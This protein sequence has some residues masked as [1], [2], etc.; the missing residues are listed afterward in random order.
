MDKRSANK[1]SSLQ[2]ISEWEIPWK[3]ESGG[4]RSKM[5]LEE[6]MTSLQFVLEDY[7]R[8]SIFCRLNT[9]GWEEILAWKGRWF[10]QEVEYSGTYFVLA[11]GQEFDSWTA[12]EEGCQLLRIGY[13]AS[14]FGASTSHGRDTHGKPSIKPRQY[15]QFAWNEIPRR[16]LSDP[17]SRIAELSRSSDGMFVTSLMDCRS[18]WI[19]DEHQHPSNVISYCFRGGGIL[20]GQQNEVRFRA[21][22]MAVIFAGTPHAFRTDL[23]GASILVCT[24]PPL[25]P[26]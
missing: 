15:S 4:R 2:I 1:A 20:T 12:G 13:T 8:D 21:G 24:V 11:P 26:E 5:L 19:L 16:R 23:G 6:S 18:G 22:Q 9:L 3:N 25:L 17:G 10:Q 14:L 7:D